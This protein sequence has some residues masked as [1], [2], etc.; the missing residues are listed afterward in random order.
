MEAKKN[1]ECLGEFLKEKQQ[2]CEQLGE[3]MVQLRDELK[4]KR[5]Q[6]KLDNNSTVLDNILKS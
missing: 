3:A 4:S 1:E 6:E 5:V 2:I